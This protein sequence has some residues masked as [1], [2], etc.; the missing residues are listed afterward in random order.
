MKVTC[1]KRDAAA[2]QLDVAIGLLF[3]DTDPLAIRTLV[4]AAY[5]ILVDIAEVQKK[6]SSWRTKLIE[7]SG[8]S[9]KDALRTLNT[10]Q[11]Y[12]KHADKDP[13]ELLSF[14]EEEN[15]HLIFMASIECGIIGHSLSFS[16]QAFQIWYH[17]LYH[18][19]FGHDTQ[20]VRTAKEVFP[21]LSKTER[22]SQLI[23]GKQFL[24]AFSEQKEMI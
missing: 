6:G 18:E 12:L 16:I 20:H 3:T 21:D 19:M 11:N 1:S 7:D 5:G 15:D 8:L 9:E 24:E 13:H 22:R 10:A 4:G 14:D 17:A 23:L 2:R